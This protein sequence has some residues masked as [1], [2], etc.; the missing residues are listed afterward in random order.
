[1]QPASG[2]SPEE[3]LHK[4][5]NDYIFQVIA[6]T[7]ASFKSGSTLIEENYA[8]F[9]YEH[10]FNHLKNKDWKIKEDRTATMMQKS[11][12]ATFGERKRFPKSKEQGIYCVKISLEYF[13][14]EETAD[15]II[16]MKD[17]NDIL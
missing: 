2:T 17:K 9:V 10:F 16:E 5:L 13:T 1:M 7:Y 6:K 3:Q 8:Y 4:Y 11:Y 14:K 12:Q 15:E